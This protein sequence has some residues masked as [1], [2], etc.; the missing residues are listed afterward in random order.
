MPPSYLCF[1]IMRSVC[2]LLVAMPPAT[3][4]G[5]WLLCGVAVSR[6]FVL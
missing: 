6:R 1:G 3:A 4:T 5:Y 2:P